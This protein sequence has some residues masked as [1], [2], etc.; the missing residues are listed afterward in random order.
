MNKESFDFLGFRYQKF[1]KTK[2]G[3]KL[4][5]MMPSKKA[6]EKGKGCNQK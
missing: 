2:C 4:P 6:D 1:G 3:R 5:Y